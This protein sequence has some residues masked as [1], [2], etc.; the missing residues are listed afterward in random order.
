M[1]S[2]SVLG[3]GCVVAVRRRRLFL[4]S[5]RWRRTG[6]DV[7]DGRIPG[8]GLRLH[9]MLPLH[10]P[11]QASREF[12]LTSLLPRQLPLTFLE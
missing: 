9:I 12:V 3:R 4:L 10:L 2:G 11:L 8:L 6:V 5:A 1:S 7:G